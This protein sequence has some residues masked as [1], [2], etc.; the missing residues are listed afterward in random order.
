MTN[1]GVRNLQNGKRKD[2]EVMIIAACIALMIA[3]SIILLTAVVLG[4]DIS[5][6]NESVVVSIYFILTGLIWGFLVLIN[7]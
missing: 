2:L 7:N 6:W 3:F 1:N 5:D 4:Q